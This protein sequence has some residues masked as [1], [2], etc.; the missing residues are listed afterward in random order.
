MTKQRSRRRFGPPRLGDDQL[1]REGEMAVIEWKEARARMK[2][3]EAAMIR[4]GIKRK[5]GKANDRT[6]D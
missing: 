4:A 2:E 3:A 5:R 6:S 1:I